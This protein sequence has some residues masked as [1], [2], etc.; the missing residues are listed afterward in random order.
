MENPLIWTA[1]FPIKSSCLKQFWINESTKWYYSL[2]IYVGVPSGNC[3]GFPTNGVITVCN[4]YVSNYNWYDDTFRNS[5]AK[6][7]P[8]IQVQF[9]VYRSF[10]TV[11]REGGRGRERSERQTRDRRHIKRKMERH[12]FHAYDSVQPPSHTWYSRHALSHIPHIPA[13]NP[14]NTSYLKHASYD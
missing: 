11:G 13:T 10:A 6:R 5:S 14:S 9:H 8:W 4:V 7:I 2:C 12:I 3:P 1:Q